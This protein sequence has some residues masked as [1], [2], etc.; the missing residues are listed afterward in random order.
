MENKYVLLMCSVLKDGKD[1]AGNSYG[2]VG[3]CIQARN[4][5]RDGNIDTGLNGILWG[6][7]PSFI[8]K[9]ILKFKWAVVK[10]EIN[11]NLLL[12]DRTT[13]ETK[14]RRGIIL[15]LGNIE[16]CADYVMSI[17]DDEQQYFAEEAKHLTEEQIIGTKAWNEK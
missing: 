7:T 3:E 10:T 2:G 13:N 9:N 11:D 17:K 15:H 14:F 8:H 4:F 1:V 6:K 16:S 5:V 12:L